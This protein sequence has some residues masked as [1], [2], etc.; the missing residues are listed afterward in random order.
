MYENQ[1]A[2][3]FNYL[4]ATACDIIFSVDLKAASLYEEK[5]QINEY[6]HI[7]G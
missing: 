3:D 2:S 5:R 4:K 1:L 6:G 7:K